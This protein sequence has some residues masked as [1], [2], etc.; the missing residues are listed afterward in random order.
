M[1]TNAPAKEHITIFKGGAFAKRIA[2]VDI[3][4]AARNLTGYS[5]KMQIRTDVDDVA[6]VLTLTSGAGLTITSLTG[7]IDIALTKA[8][9]AALTIQA[10]VWDLWIDNGGIDSPEY[11]VEGGVVVRKM[12]TQ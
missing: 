11:L 3:N 6:A 2:V 10:G 9:T 12:V 8:Q 7:L 4:N 1:A 5:A